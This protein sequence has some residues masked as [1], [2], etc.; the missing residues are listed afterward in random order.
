MQKL[1]VMV[2]IKVLLQI[3]FLIFVFWF[4]LL[5]YENL[6]FIIVAYGESKGSNT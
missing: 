1:Y 5:L 6:K 2:H 3:V 4:W